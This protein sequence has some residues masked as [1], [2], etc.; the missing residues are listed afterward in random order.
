MPTFCCLPVTDGLQLRVT[1]T[2]V[3]CGEMTDPEPHLQSEN[4]QHAK[5]HDARQR[6]EAHQTH[7][8]RAFGRGGRCGV[9][10][11]G[12]EGFR[13]PRLCERAQGLRGADA[14]ANGP[15]R[16]TLGR[17]GK[18]SP[19]QARKRAAEVIDRIKRGLPPFPAPSQPELTVA[20]LAE[21]YLTGHVAVN[22]RAAT[23]AT[24]R[25]VIGAH[26]LPELGD[27]PIGEV[28]RSRVAKFHYRRRATPQAANTAVR[29]L[30]ADCSRWP[31]RG[32]W[33]GRGEWRAR[34][35]GR[36]SCA[37]RALALGESCP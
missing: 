17:Y 3:A 13:P 9:L 32:S 11:P 35:V 26:I 31:R 4:S 36:H 30:S 15:K 33:S 7:R 19:E 8:R 6:P 2:P 34:R 23:L 24:Y 28:D 16:A 10:G 12:P 1:L 14:R 21:R 20:G 25:Y 5:V 37:S 18:L 22:C 27:L 29:I